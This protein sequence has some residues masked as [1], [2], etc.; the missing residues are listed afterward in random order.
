M[1]IISYLLN[2]LNGFK[3]GID[4]SGN[5]QLISYRNHPFVGVGGDGGGGNTIVLAMTEERAEHI[6][7]DNS[8]ELGMY[9]NAYGGTSLE[10]A[11]YTEEE[12]TII[13]KLADTLIA[14]NPVTLAIKFISDYDGN[15]SIVQGLA[16]QSQYDASINKI[17]LLFTTRESH[18]QDPATASVE[19]HKD[20]STSNWYIYK[21]NVPLA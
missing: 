19:L 3:I 8:S 6:D 15:S 11:D 17:E 12:Q 20:E 16:L 13:N 18:S 2:K 5:A 9:L 21:Q 7:Y 14:A 4:D 1:K 10:D